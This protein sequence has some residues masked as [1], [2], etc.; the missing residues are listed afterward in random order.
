MI[1]RKHSIL[2]LT[3][4]ATLFCSCESKTATGALTGGALG[5]GIGGIVGG[6]EGALIGG[7][8]GVIVGGLIGAALDEKEQRTLK[9]E[10]PQTYRRVD[11][12]QQLSVNDVINL[13]NA[14]ISDK[15]I[16]E[17]LQKTDSHFHLN[18]YQIDRLHDA[19]VSE[20]VIDYMK[21]S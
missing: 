15:K 14:G 13:S 9:E 1:N 17:L 7:A 4:T 10:S 12:G 16:I 8:A 5:A 11:D 21:H 3:L 2:L 20:K 19:G 18:S 6:G